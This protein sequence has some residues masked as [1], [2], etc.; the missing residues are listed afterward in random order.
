MDQPIKLISPITGKLEAF[1]ETLPG[2]EKTYFCVGSGYMGIDTYVPNSDY[3]KQAEQT[4]PLLVR[5]LKF[6][7]KDRNMNWYPTIIDIP[8]KGIVFPDG[9]SVEDWWWYYAPVVDISEQEQAQYP[10]PEGGFYTKRIAIDQGQKFDKSD[11]KSAIKCLGI[12][13]E[14]QYES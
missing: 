12:L 3:T 5:D 1:Q 14:K 2:G 4:M 11:F 7:D 9:A 6:Y 10:N 13:I 8:T